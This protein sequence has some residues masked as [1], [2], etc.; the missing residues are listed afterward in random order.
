MLSVR[1]TLNRFIKKSDIGKR[2]IY[3]KYVLCL[4]FLAALLSLLISVVKN[5]YQYCI[6]FILTG[7]IV[8]FFSKNMTVILVLAIAFATLLNN[9]MRGKRLSV[10]G[11]EGADAEM[12]MAEMNTTEEKETEKKP[13]EKNMTEKKS[14]EAVRRDSPKPTETSRPKPTASALVDSLKDQA[15]DLQDAQK[16]IIDG[17]Q[18]IEPYMERA[19]LLIDS[20]NK[21]AKEIEN[22]KDKSM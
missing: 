20:I 5:D 2:I 18:Q 7:F 21:T 10:E 11:M 1:K 19:E 3:N 6:F 4:V 16:N 12:N 9:I 15:Y 14:E 8:S 22:L 13:A 17:F